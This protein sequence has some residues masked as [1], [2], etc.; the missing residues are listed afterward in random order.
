[1]TVAN[2]GEE[3]RSVRVQDV[4]ASIAACDRCPRMRPHRRFST[5]GNLGARWVMIGEAPSKE[6][7]DR[8]KY[9]LGVSGRRLRRL[10]SSATH[11]SESRSLEL[12][13]DFYLTDLVKCLPPRGKHGIT[14]AVIGVCG[15]FLTDEL[16]AL[17]PRLVVTVGAEPTKWIMDRY[18]PSHPGLGSITDLHKTVD[19]DAWCAATW[20]LFLLRPFVHP[21][22]GNKY[23]GSWDAYEYLLRDGLAA[24]IRL[25]V[26]CSA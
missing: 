24:A 21:S 10:V 25:A 3:A 22:W 2:D 26:Q 23:L 8:A 17:H 1:M 4:H 14:S 15:Q 12:D 11:P 6:S 9:W 20:G 13:R 16:E 5:H 7:I 19:L 18:P